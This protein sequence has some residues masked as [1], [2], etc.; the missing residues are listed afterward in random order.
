MLRPLA[1]PLPMGFLG[2]AVA[3][4]A[5]ACLQLSWIPSTQSHLV[6]LG[7]LVFTIPLQSFAAA[8]GFLARDPVAGTGAGLLAG[9]WAVTAAL[10]RASAP[11]SMSP[12][13]GV[14]LCGVAVALLVPATMAIGRLAAAAVFF[15]S[16]ARFALTGVAE[17]RGGGTWW[18]ASGWVGLALVLASVYAALAFELRGATGREWLP[19]GRLARRPVELAAE[20]GVRGSL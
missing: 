15:L 5:F 19:I 13:L 8:L 17:L 3:S 9:G 14:L 10:T 4:W 6:A 12:A 2:Q 20:P 11:G 18:P 1:T 16:V 7:V